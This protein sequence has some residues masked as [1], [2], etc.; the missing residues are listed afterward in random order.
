MRRSISVGQTAACV[1]LLCL[2]ARPALAQAKAASPK[3]PITTSSDE[4]RRSYV[5][6]RDLAERLRGTDARAFFERAVEKDRG[7]ALAYLG[8]ANTSGTTKAFIDAIARAAALVP[9]VSAGERHMILGAEAGLK[10]D[11]A[12]ALA[13]YTELVR[14]YPEDERAQ[15]LLANL[16]FGRQDYDAAVKHFVRA[17]AINP[18]FSQPYNQLGYAYRFLERFE[19]AEKTFKTYTQLIPNDP[20]PYDSYAELLMKMG[21]FDESI[22][23]YERALAIDPHFVASYVGIG[24]NYLC[25]GRPERARDAFAR[26]LAA[27]RNTGERRLAHFWTAASYVHEGATDK[28]LAELSAESALAEAEHDRASMSGDLTQMGNILREAGRFDEALVKYEEAVEV[29]NTAQ[30]PEEV[31]AATRRNLAF[32]QGRVAA[33][34]NDLATAKAKAAE[35]TQQIAATKAPFELRQQHELAALVALADRQPAV[36]VQELRLANQQ[37]PRILYLTAVALRQTGDARGA[38][39]AAAKAAKFNGLSFDYAYVKARAQQIVGT[40]QY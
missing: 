12:G 33:A 25:M 8:L 5:Q 34:K 23:T 1:L 35:Y 20:N 10:G 17:I 21:R 40:G 36:A 38:A 9:D 24:S 3:I 39:T 4:A 19:E 30:A 29:M 7:F 6:G 28:A 27:A 32:E 11:A 22:A 15:T 2:V 13:H 18:A 26:L 14:L 31:K 37:D 16:Y